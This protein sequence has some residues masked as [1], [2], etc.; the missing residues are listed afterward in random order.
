MKRSEH[1]IAAAVLLTAL[2]LVAPATGAAEVNVNINVPLPGLVISSPPSM[3]V[4]PGTY[5]YYPPE[6]SANIFFYQGYWYRPHHEGWFIANGYNGPW[7]PVAAGHVPH[8]VMS[9]QHGYRDMHSRHERIAY[10]DMKKN[11]RGWERE[12]HWDRSEREHGERH[13]DEPDRDNRGR[14][15][16][17]GR[18]ESG[19]HDRG[20]R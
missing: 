1:I 10:N 9:I 2:I 18:D 19:G 15:G 7:R 6:V 12:R 4:I 3:A 14:H 16:D 8:A 13:H 17:E 20:W 11:W 5:V